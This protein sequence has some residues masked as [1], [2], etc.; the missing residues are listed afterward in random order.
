MLVNNETFKTNKFLKLLDL[1]KGKSLIVS[2]VVLLLVISILLLALEYTKKELGASSKKQLI[3]SFIKHIDY[4][5]EVQNLKPL[6]EMQ[7]DIKFKHFS[8]ISAI[9]D[10]LLKEDLTLSNLKGANEWFP[11]RIRVGNKKYK[12]KIRLKGD[13]NAHRDHPDKW[14][15][16][17]KIKDGEKVWGMSTFSIHHPKNQSYAACSLANNF[18][19]KMG[20]LTPRHSHINVFVNGKN[21]GIMNLEE[22]FSKELIESQKRRE[23]IIIKVDE[24][25]IFSFVEFVYKKSHP[26]A[27]YIFEEFIAD[28]KK[29]YLKPYIKTSLPSEDIKNKHYK[30][31]VGLYRNLLNKKIEASNLFDTKSFAKLFALINLFA[32][33]ASHIFMI[34]NIRIYFNPI[35]GKFEP[36]A[37]DWAFLETNRPIYQEEYLI[38][39]FSSK[40][41]G[42]SF[43]SMILSDKKIFD[44]YIIESKKLAEDVLDG[45]YDNIF[46]IYDDDYKQISAE[47]LAP[48]I[49]EKFNSD[50][51]KKYVY[52]RAEW[53]KNNIENSNYQKLISTIKET[54]SKIIKGDKK[55]TNSL[56]KY[57]NSILR[58]YEVKKD[59]KDFIEL[60]NIMPEDV[61]VLDIRIDAKGVKSKS[62]N[63]IKYPIIVK[64]SK[65]NSTPE[66]VLV[67]YTKISNLKYKIEVYA[68]FADIKKSKIRKHTAVKYA[69]ADNTP[70][71]PKSSIKEQL[72]K[73]KFLQKK[74]KTIFVKSGSWQVKGNIIIPED[75][76]FKINQGTTLR[77]NAENMIISHGKVEF[78]GTKKSPIILTGINKNQWR[79]IVVLEANKE[80][81]INNVIIKDLSGVKHKEWVLTG[82]VNFYKSNVKI[83]NTTISDNSSEDALNI[84]NSDFD[85][86]NITIKNTYSDGFDCDFCTGTIKNSYFENIGISGGDAIDVS[87][88]DIEVQN[89]KIIKTSDKAISVGEKSIVKVDSIIVQDALAAFVSKDGSNLQVNN[90][91]ATNIKISCFMA[92]KKK[93]EYD[94]ATLKV[95]DTICKNA[96]NNNKSQIGSSLIIDDVRQ[97]NIELDVDELY[98]TFMRKL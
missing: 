37:Y 59:G 34:Q 55:I 84:I 52:Q 47:L 53:I 3:T 62:L 64:G 36:I 29:S 79:G 67:P 48:V 60:V 41:P 93:P 63:D 65:G 61:A 32:D 33:E 26:D 19:R 25:D 15:F 95:N 98:K 9:R 80:S 40:Y 96:A 2:F 12:A 58:A 43:G 18:A 50:R 28:H 51:V 45:V 69:L 85:I 91:G 14:S 88:S 49:K 78:L 57:D 11:A 39:E 71:I 23:G 76:E 81:I 10:K 44:Q 87:G 8:K 56:K 83:S 38:E 94:F 82:A 54:K 35:S 97:E 68:K 89:T 66:S 75:Y 22:S 70:F 74:G 13:Y 7:L 17:I 77:F 73:N 27:L 5:Y 31:S 72:M 20:V 21:I 6:P 86:D 30:K 42:Y 92:Y 4:K 16:K 1:I 90:S 24:S 46:N